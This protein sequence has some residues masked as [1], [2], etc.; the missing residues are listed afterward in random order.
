MKFKHLFLPVFSLFTLL[1]TGC[2][3]KTENL[4]F[5][6]S[7]LPLETRVDDL[8]SR[9]TL[10]EKISQMQN[11]AVAIDRLGIPE[12]NWWNECLHGV[13]RNGIATVFPQAIG[14]AATWDPELIQKEADVIS[15]EARAK[16]REA[17]EKGERRIYQG[18]TFWSPNINI[19]RDPRWGRGQET[20]GEDPYL[21]SRIG[22]AFVK[23][24]QGDD[25]NYFKVIAT[26]KHF[27]VHSGPEP[28]RHTFDAN[29]S[30]TDLYETYFPAFKA[31]ITEGGAYSIMGAYNSFRG[32]PCC[33]NPFLL[34]KIL[35][36]EWGFKGYVVSDCGAINDFYTG[37]KIVKNAEEASA[38]AVK[39]G[40]DLTCGGEYV[41]LD[42]AVRDSLITEA[43]IDTSVKRLMRARFKLGMFDPPE[44][45]PYAQ[46]PVS[47]NNTGENRQ[48]ALK[49]ARESIVLLKNKDHLLPL[50][51][52]IPSLAVIG[53]YADYLDNLLGNYNGTP[54]NPV[55]IL[56]GIKNRVGEHTRVLY[57]QGLER[58][59]EG[60]MLR[61]VDSLYLRPGRGREGYGLYDEYFNNAGL[62]GAPLLTRVEPTGRLYWGV[63]S[64]GKGIPKDYFS[65]RRTG[66]LVP[67][68]DGYYELGLTTDDKGRL[69]LDGELKID[70]WA[71]FKV[72]A[73]QTCR[74]KLEGG[75]EYDLRIEYAD[76]TEYAGMRF[77]WRRLHDQSKNIEMMAQAIEAVKKS[78]LAIVVAGISPRLEGEEMPVKLE[79]FSGGDRTNLKIPAGMSRL[80]REVKKTGKPVILVLTN[81]SALAV[82]W[83][84]DNIPAI[85]EVWYPG[86]EG[87]NA[88]ADVLFGM[89][90]PAGRLPVTFYK[91]VKDLPPFDDYDMDGRT[92][93]YFKG[94]P[95]YPFGYGLSY[96]GFDYLEANLPA[97]AVSAADT[98]M[99]S[100][101]LKNSGRYGGDEVV[102]VYLKP[103]D[104]ESTL[105]K[106][107]VAFKRVYIEKEESL[108]VNIPI[109]VQNLAQFD[110]SE[111]TFVLHPGKV[112][113]LIGASSA[114]LRIEKELE[115]K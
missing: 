114:D 86:E 79:G 109:V 19:F 42:Q 9:M 85:L 26:P 17:Q 105:I 75:K 66:K 36:E 57:A 34:E 4:P 33:G 92:Y 110:E 80:I 76:E 58:V 22:V 30:D 115:V 84:Q 20:Y 52:D 113:L 47:A 70:N 11:D 77:V 112:K 21:T 100:V 60:M 14:M 89:Y 39:A 91:S 97:E 8:V 106:K 12:Y 27:G 83:E 7:D 56:Q 54:S 61:T 37:H 1:L 38:M 23:G 71:P 31:L 62:S 73:M 16:Y 50:D 107:L 64:P 15:T 6:N 32:K 90:N 78:D 93:K 48:L 41:A 69:Y 99:L 10:K 104:H 35:R 28:L 67:D 45:V 3:N 94:I 18:L 96:S 24:L 82:N 25:P 88:V 49:V 5:M 68:K 108:Q 29:V 72:N 87:G 44:K 43:Q 59:E 63:K 98:V 65:V 46:I 111:H 53:P 55:T 51:K 2:T 95:L 102:Q 103:G 13:A 101:T 74:V 40:C 81:G